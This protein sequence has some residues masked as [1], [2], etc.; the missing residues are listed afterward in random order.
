MFT[1][2]KKVNKSESELEGTFFISFLLESNIIKWQVRTKFV[3]FFFRFLSR[4]NKKKPNEKQALYESLCEEK[5]Q[6]KKIMKQWSQSLYG[7]GTQVI[8]FQIKKHIFTN[9][10]LQTI[11]NNDA[12]V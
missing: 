3:C 9:I 12:K 8:P 2:K 4:N 6:K 1:N 5:K 10:S 11:G 7:P